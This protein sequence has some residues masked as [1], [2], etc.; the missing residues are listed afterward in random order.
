MTFVLG[1]SPPEYNNLTKVQQDLARNEQDFD[2]VMINEYF[3]ES[4]ILLKKLLCWQFEDIL[5]VKLNQR[6][7]RPKQELSNITKQQIFNWNRADLMFYDFFNKTFWRKIKE[8]G[9]EFWDDLRQFREMN[10]RIQEMCINSNVTKIIDVGNVLIHRLK[11]RNSLSNDSRRLCTDMLRYPHDYVKY[12]RKK[13]Q[14][15]GS[16]QS[17]KAEVKRRFNVSDYGPPEKRRFGDLW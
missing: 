11:T 15:A 17:P 1:L 10:S 12:F 6:P 2:L 9:P 13:I 8:Y 16:Y 4:L 5:Y 14:P 7:P 3:D